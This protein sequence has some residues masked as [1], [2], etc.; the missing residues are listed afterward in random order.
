M[1]NEAPTRR[2]LITVHG[3][4][5]FGKWQDQLEGELRNRL[6]SSIHV[7]H[8]RYG[9]FTLFAFLI[10]PLRWLATRRFQAELLSQNRKLEWDRIDIVAHSFGTHLVCW[11]LLRLP[12]PRRPR[13]HTIIL[14]SSV[15]K[16]SFPVRKLVGQSVRR[17]VNDCATRDVVLLFNQTF[18]LFTGMGGLKGIT[19]MEND[20]FRNRYFRFRH[21]GY[22]KGSF[23]EEYWLPVLLSD[24]GI[25]PH[26]ER[27]PHPLNDLIML[28]LNNFEPVKLTGY[29]LIP[30]LILIHLYTLRQANKIVSG[31]YQNNVKEDYAALWRLSQTR[32]GR[33][34]QA[35][36]VRLLQDATGAETLDHNRAGIIAALGL[37]AVPFATLRGYATSGPCA[38]LS[39]SYFEGCLTIAIIAGD[40][41]SFVNHILDVLPTLSRKDIDGK[42]IAGGME[43]SYAEEMSGAFQDTVPN[44]KTG[45]AALV[46]A[47]IGQL[48]GKIRKVDDIIVAETL[49]GSLRALVTN[50]P[51]A[52]KE[53]LADRLVSEFPEDDPRYREALAYAIQDLMPLKSNQMEVTVNR[54]ADAI[55]AGEQQLR[56]IELARSLTR[57]QAGRIEKR[58]GSVIDGITAGPDPDVLKAARL[59]LAEADVAAGGQMAEPDMRQGASRAILLLKSTLQSGK[60]G[61]PRDFPLESIVLEE[62]IGTWALALN[63]ESA[64]DIA[65]QLADLLPQ[66]P[67]V[68]DALR[69][70]TPKLSGNQTELG[71]KIASALGSKG[72]TNGNLAL[73]LTALAAKAQV[74]SD[75]ADLGFKWMMELLKANPDA[76]LQTVML[77]AVPYLNS[78][79]AKQL[80]DR[81]AEVVNHAN[82]VNV[83]A[84][85]GALVHL[86]D[87][88]HGN[89]HDLEAVCSR[90]VSLLDEPK[91]ADAPSLGAL[92]ARL[93]KH[94]PREKVEECATW[95][96]NN[97]GKAAASD[98]PILDRK[99][100][101]DRG[102]GYYP[103]A[104]SLS[105]ALAA[106]AS[107]IRLDGGQAD[108]ATNTILDLFARAVRRK[109]PK[110]D[111]SQRPK[112]L[113]YFPEWDNQTVPALASAL[114]VL[115][116][117]LNPAEQATV[118]NRILDLVTQEVEL[119]GHIRPLAETAWLMT[120]FVDLTPRLTGDQR[121]LS[122]RIEELRDKSTD[123]LH[124]HLSDSLIG[125]A[126]NADATGRK[127]IL[128]ASIGEPRS[129]PCAVGMAKA[130][131]GELPLLLDMLKWPVC[132]ADHGW[133]ALREY[134][135]AVILRIAEI[136][137]V[138]PAKF[139]A[140]KTVGSRR[141]FKPDLPSF[142]AWLKEQKDES[143]RPFDIDGPPRLTPMSAAWTVSQS[144]A[145]K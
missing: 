138:D 33:V 131:T 30:L 85:A 87:A 111:L 89:A 83:G 70:L 135:A 105:S 73:A 21:A 77:P 91:A 118:A 75:D 90:I 60:N 34:Q 129:I 55:G 103:P 92:L 69:F 11:S 25:V 125:L 54:F 132:P 31:F 107:S 16:S 59:A 62:A 38:A 46:A 56:R 49:L 13:I 3:I 121:A 126:A 120:V 104:I 124:D 45:Q 52:A 61:N 64:S 109:T 10:P 2:L 117:Q 40:E 15:L 112:A 12:E 94:L 23:M 74:G 113:E 26:D 134:R 58:I 95:I 57:E 14:A 37:R 7:C 88:G 81:I 53:R 22:F 102:T 51:D 29:I 28:V 127:A 100:V 24:S 36:L 35:A 110:T 84:F 4:R 44:L 18:V 78:H 8:Y 98:N 123:E 139:G 101:P 116:A 144:S 79:Q 114:K 142:L 133:D 67:A 17:L 50:L 143:G 86:A 71:R 145:Q 76:A 5:T 41:A 48:I 115:A 42:E 97:L 72:A 140:F 137:H 27:K 65:N 106:F 39:R 63:G 108:L 128:M 66:V 1:P 68:A 122:R 136:T 47:R 19:G 43:E 9:F 141:M 32:S 130:G 6:G 80:A 119:A 96:T 93:G 20:A 99:L 82:I